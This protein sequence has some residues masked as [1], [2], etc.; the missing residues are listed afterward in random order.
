M[1][2]IS[3][4]YSLTPPSSPTRSL[5]PYRPW[6]TETTPPSSPTR[7]LSPFRPWDTEAPFNCVE[8]IQEISPRAAAFS[9]AALLGLNATEVQDSLV[10]NPPVGGE[11]KA[12][13][14]RTQFTSAQL[15]RLESEFEKQQYMVGAERQALAA[16]L[17]L[18]D[19]N[20]KIWFQNRRIKWRK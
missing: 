20:L 17:N 12:K 18:T 5:S 8:Q 9:I 19:R 7:S 2:A 1:M 10:Q 16:E 4:H 13:R 3:S 6:N 14:N 11:G 15:S